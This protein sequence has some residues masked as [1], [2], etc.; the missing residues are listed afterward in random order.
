MK[1][2]KKNQ[3]WQWSQGQY[4]L[5][6]RLSALIELCRG[7]FDEAVFLPHGMEDARRGAVLKAAAKPTDG[8]LHPHQ[9]QSQQQK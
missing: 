9:R 3:K 6:N 1:F 5:N 4:F 8:P 7:V 2:D